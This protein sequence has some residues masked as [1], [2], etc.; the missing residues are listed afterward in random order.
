MRRYAVLTEG[1]LDSIYAKTAHGV[2]R[3]RP[4]EVAVVVDSAFAGRTVR[5]V[6]PS[7]DSSA[8]VVGSLREALPYAPNALLVGVATDGGHLPNAMRPAVLDAV[9]AGLDVVSGLHE[10]LQDDV[11]IAAAAAQSGSVL[12]DVRVPPREV[13][14]FQGRS[15]RPDQRVVLAVGS[16]CAVGKMT[17][18]LEIERFALAAGARV[19][20]AATGQTGIMIAGSGIAVDGVVS[21]FL[22]G[23]AEM[24]VDEALERGDVALVEGQGSV[25]HPAYAPV[26]VGLLYGCAPDALVL[27]HRP[28]S[29]TIAGFATS[30][31]PLRELVRVHEDFL[32]YVKPAR[33]LA[34]A[35]DTSALDP[36]AADRA[37]FAAEAETGLPADDPVRNGGEKLWRAIE[38]RRG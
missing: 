14:L 22:T 6:L 18:M 15:R 28:G 17:V 30:I 7:V 23:A 34:I 1:K 8:P 24:L 12:F 29:T 16:D 9:A 2:L 38:T 4:G 32:A 20:F 13:P 37:I 36:N 27:C 5:E 3:Y 31:P 33:V 35:L 25:L 11:E 19:A 21:D 10:R 26:T